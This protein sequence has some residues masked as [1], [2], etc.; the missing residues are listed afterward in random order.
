MTLGFHSTGG[1]TH[2]V[3]IRPH[4]RLGTQ[5]I[6]QLM[7]N[8]SPVDV[9]VGDPVAV[10]LQSGWQTAR[11]FIGIWGDSTRGENWW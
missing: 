4:G 3:R 1:I 6:L 2:L 10:H 8:D 7:G 11:D 5:V 9:E